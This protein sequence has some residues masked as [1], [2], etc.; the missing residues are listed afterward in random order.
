MENLWKMLELLSEVV[1]RTKDN[2]RTS[3]GQDFGYVCIISLFSKSA[4][5]TGLDGF[6]G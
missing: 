1:T 4:Y 5:G 6:R 2:Q 3:S